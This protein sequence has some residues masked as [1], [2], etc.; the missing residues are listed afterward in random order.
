MTQDALTIRDAG[1]A[2]AAAIATIYNQGI[3]DRIATLETEERPPEE[4]K[5]WL[6]ARGPRHPVLVAER[7][8]RVVGWGSLNQFNPRKAYD[9]VAD[10]SV[11]VERAWRG[12]GVGGALLRALIGRAKQLGYHKLVLSAF[13]WNAA[14]MALYQKYGFRTVG[15]YEE[16]GFLDEKWVDTI[17][18][19]KIL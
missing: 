14:G 5:Q 6:A 3:A 4:R 2:D 18:M 15:I 1:E 8:G 7:N 10:F 11:Y 19:E 16:Q 13:P 17:I 12:K 9:F